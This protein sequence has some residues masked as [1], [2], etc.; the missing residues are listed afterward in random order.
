MFAISLT[1]FLDSI[2]CEMNVFV[3]LL[4]IELL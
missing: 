3:Q 2:I 1:M 4:Q